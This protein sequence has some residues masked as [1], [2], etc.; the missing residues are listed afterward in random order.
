[1][2]FGS[3]PSTLSAQIN[4][5][6]NDTRGLLLQRLNTSGS[7]EWTAYNVENKLRTD[8]GIFGEEGDAPVA[9]TWTNPES[10]ELAFLR[11]KIL[12][13]MD[14]AGT[15]REVRIPELGP[16]TLLRIAD[17]DNNGISDI[18]T[19]TTNRSSVPWRI[20]LNPL[21]TPANRTFKSFGSKN[22]IPLLLKS[23]G[24][25]N[26]ASL[27]TYSNGRSARISLCTIPCKK[28]KSYT[29]SNLP[30]DIQAEDAFTLSSGDDD[31]DR[32]LVR[33][34]NQSFLIDLRDDLTIPVAIDSNT[35]VRSVKL[36]SSPTAVQV[37]QA[38]DGGKITVYS[39]D[40]SE[41]YTQFDADEF[42][43]VGDQR[44]LKAAFGAKKT[45]A[46]VD[47]PVTNVE[48][49]PTNES[50]FTSTPAVLPTGEY[51]YTPT[52][53]PTP[54]ESQSF[55]E[56]PTFT[57][58][59][60]SAS[61]NTPLPTQT[62][63]STATNTPTR[64]FTRTPV[65][66][67]TATRTNTPTRTN[68]RTST[69]VTTPG[70]TSTPTVGTTSTATP[71]ISPT[72]TTTSTA[73][74]TP[75]NTPTV[76]NTRTPSSTPTVTYTPTV[77]STPTAATIRVSKIELLDGGTSQVLG[78]LENNVDILL[79]TSVQTVR[80]RFTTVGSV[81]SIQVS[82]NNSLIF[83]L[84][85]GTTVTPAF[86]LGAGPV[87]IAAAPVD[88]SGVVQTPTIIN[89]Q[90]IITSSTFYG[91]GMAAHSLSN[92]TIGTSSRAV[93]SIRFKAE[94]SGVLRKLQVYWIFKNTTGYHAGDGGIIRVTLRSDDGTASH[95]PTSEV[96]STLIFTPNLPLVNPQSKWDIRMVPMTFPTPA[97]ITRGRL[98]HIHFENIHADPTNNWISLNSMYNWTRQSTIAQPVQDTT[99]LSIIRRTGTGSWAPIRGYVP[100]YGLYIDTNNDGTADVEQGQSYMEFWASS[101]SG[102]KLDG[103]TRVRQSFRPQTTLLL[104]QLHISMGKYS[105]SAPASVQIKTSSGTILSSGSIASGSLPLVT[106]A[107]SCPQ[108]INDYCHQWTSA[109]L[110]PQPTLQAGQTYYLELS[111]TSGSQY[112]LHMIRDG[113][114]QYDFPMTG[115]LSSGN[116]QIST[117][118]GGTWSGVTFWGNSNRL[119]GDLSFYFDSE[120]L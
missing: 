114:I 63:T 49:T 79:P 44:P 30:K 77:T 46:P 11:N 80:L 57:A 78:T 91:P 41:E 51:T 19:I 17:I 65:P 18:I 14:A 98:Y 70:Q 94:T 102:L 6:S 82:L 88:G 2:F 35:I 20:R 113:S 106:A 89:S 34:S 9:G 86:A 21:V 107:S 16:R 5:A 61:T 60:A 67:N 64:T 52:V 43:L 84:T 12:Y 115:S 24:R 76:T 85:N 100:I 3:V 1:L 112:Q 117:N 119:D 53:L 29:L 27:L 8:L 59:F 118:N 93:N 83:S 48:K 22:Q 37:L 99:D 104:K 72:S 66:T 109:E 81:S 33:Y 40:F 110:T 32:I 56:I 7:I 23:Q 108:G 50:T 95:N 26:I 36:T 13:I 54:T 68:T 10:A 73:S 97:S 31:N 4:S 38:R 101:S 116:A 28:P 25:G 45:P 75:S 92:A 47:T 42:L 120:E 69:P 55:T 105:G 111:T 90:V 87:R 39:S 96:L 103:T 71:V 62:R 74:A 15:T 58:T